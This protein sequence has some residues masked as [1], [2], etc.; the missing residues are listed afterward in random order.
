M[1][2]GVK[3]YVQDQITLAKL[4]VVEGAGKAAGSIVAMV[5][6]AIFA[7][8][9]IVFLSIAGAYYLS[10]YFGSYMYGFLA[11]SGVFL[12]LMILLVVFKKLY[13]IWWQI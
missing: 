11:M 12:L 3:N 8:L 2:G 4:E 9:F 1:F 6:M 10:V 13:R 5:F 7:V